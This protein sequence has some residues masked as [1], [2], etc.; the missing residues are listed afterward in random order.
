MKRREG[1]LGLLGVG[2][3]GGSLGGYDQYTLCACV[4]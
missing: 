3:G 2:V 1:I 4:E